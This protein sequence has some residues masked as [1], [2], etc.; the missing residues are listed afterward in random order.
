MPDKLLR[1]LKLPLLALFSKNFYLSVL[2][3]RGTGFAYLVFL[4]LVLALPATFKVYEV[5]QI[6]KGYEVSKLVAQIPPS[7]ISASGTLSPK[8]GAADTAAI[9]N[10]RGELVM[11]YNPT[12]APLDADLSSAPLELTAQSL[13]IRAGGEVNQLPWSSI[14]STN[15]DFEPYQAAAALEQVL[16]SSLLAFWPAVAAYF[17]SMLAFNTLVTAL[18]A[19]FLFYFAYRLLLSFG[20]CL[21]LM[22][23]ANT[24]CA[25]FLVLQ[26][27]IYLPISFGL[28]LVLPLIYAFFF[29]RDLRRTVEQLASSQIKEARRAA[30]AGES[31]DAGAAQPQNSQSS[32]ERQEPVKEDENGKGGRFIA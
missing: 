23:Y 18:A 26:F 1:W 15:A 11:V 2:G 31:P 16:N 5:V 4:S 7:F 28:L 9:R 24:I 21:R 10:S 14:F 17:F 6:F 32:T 20:Q 27:F 12:G 25:L 13:I 19:K 29:G 3:K 8:S 22:A 30:D